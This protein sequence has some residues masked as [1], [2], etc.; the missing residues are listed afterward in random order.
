[1]PLSDP[2]LIFTILISVILVA[3]L[4]AERLR[5]PDLVLLLLAG[6]VLGPHGTGLIERS[7]AITLLGSVGLLYIMFHAGLEIDLHRFAEIRNRS[8]IFGLLTFGI[9]QVFGTLLAYYLL[10]F[11]WPASILLASLFGAHTLLAY[12]IASRLGIA[13][14][15]AVAVT[16]GSTIINTTLA[17]LVLAVIA[18]SARGGD[19]GLW[20]W[21][22][23]GLGMAALSSLIWWGLP[24]LARW[25]FSNVPE[26]GGSQFLFVMAMLCASAYLS[27]Y[28]RME[29]IIGAFLAG[30]ALNRLIPEQSALMNR[31]E[32][33][34]N[35]L[36]IPFFLISVGML[37][38]PGA[39]TGNFRGWLVAG[40]MV[41]TVITSKWLATKLAGA[42]FGYNREEEHVMFGLSVV[43]AASTLAAVLIGYELEILD[44]SV[45]NGAIAMIFVTCPL[46]AW[47]VDRYGRKLAAR[48]RDLIVQSSPEQRVMVAVANFSSASRLL[49]L[50][51]L[52]RKPDVPGGIHP[53]TIVPDEGETSEAVRQGENL[54]ARCLSHASAADIPIIPGV[55]VGMNV[56]DGIIRAAKELRAETVLIGWGEERTTAS[57]IFGTILKQLLAQCPVKL[58]LCRL[59]Q[60][61]NTTRR[62]I[63]P[64]PP[65]FDRRGD[66]MLIMNDIKRLAKAI[67]AQLYVLMSDPETEMRLQ[68][69][70]DKARPSVP[71]RIEAAKD[72]IGARFRL[73]NDIGPDDMTI[74]PLER[75][76]SPLWSPSMDRLFEIT[77]DRFPDMNLLAVYP[78]LFSEDKLSLPVLDKTAIVIISCGD[79]SAAAGARDALRQ[80]IRERTSWTPQQQNSV[81]EL[82]TASAETYP[83]EIAPGKILL[84]AHSDAVENTTILIGAGAW[85]WTLPGCAAPTRLILALVSPRDQSPERHLKIL[86]DIAR[87][88]H[89]SAVLEQPHSP[90]ITADMAAVLNKCLAGDPDDGSQ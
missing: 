5:V 64:L 20:F 75:R 1:M 85:S 36:F 68:N 18:D 2:I 33:A 41:F 56:S 45:L 69:I 3:P 34:G 61:L 74:L 82:L 13:R 39:I 76:Q 49:D 22:R 58:V 78:A 12:P 19:I 54:L 42:W 28:A 17:L 47:L 88:L 35:A 24:W 27:Y 44:V 86:S 79:L 80:M 50:A 65:L 77:A 87:C 51:F 40:T 72:W 52:L 7:S 81:W 11:D 26:K 38:D 14:N 30:A 60:P 10:S 73:F 53:I 46:G 31:L 66:I 21:L 71:T 9:P 6:A 43:K 8:I 89:D 63:V 32:F 16:V 25:F 67:G 83:V 70:L 29:P 37:V 59:V 57:R 15:E 84:H 62:L 90:S 55:R 4:M 48:S 23:I